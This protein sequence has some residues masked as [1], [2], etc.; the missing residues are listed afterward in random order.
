MKPSVDLTGV[1][2]FRAA[3]HAAYQQPEPVVVAKQWIQSR[4]YSEPL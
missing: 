4:L 3:T 2:V 1:I